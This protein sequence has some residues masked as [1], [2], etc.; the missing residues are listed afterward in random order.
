MNLWILDNEDGCINN[1]K[2]MNIYYTFETH[3]WILGI[4]DIDFNQ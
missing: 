4:R 2:L 1:N 3:V